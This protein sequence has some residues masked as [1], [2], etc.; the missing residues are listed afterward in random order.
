MTEQ[1]KREWQ[2]F[3]KTGSLRAYLSYRSAYADSF[4]KEILK[5]RN[6]DN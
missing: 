3:Q 2:K 1:Q 6:A 5:G 4:D